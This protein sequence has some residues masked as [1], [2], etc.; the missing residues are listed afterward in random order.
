MEA[1]ALA[2]VMPAR[3]A[4]EASLVSMRAASVPLELSRGYWAA[5]GKPVAAQPA[6]KAVTKAPAPASEP[7]TPQAP[8]AKPALV[9]AKPA[10]VAAKPQPAAAA[11]KREAQAP[12]AAAPVAKPAPVKTA[13]AEAPMAKPVPAATAKPA[14]TTTTAKAADPVE[15]KPVSAA[16]SAKPTPVKPLP[17]DAARNGKPDD[18]TA[19][20]GLGP[21]LQELLN[22]MGIFHLDQIAGWSAGEAS[23]MDDNLQ[24]VKGRV[25]RDN[26]IAQAKALLDEK[27]S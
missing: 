1:A 12:V 13:E 20:K 26:W 17:I 7:A 4:L 14:P 11:V 24:G 9:A 3:F 22:R 27:V 6:A 16:A 2:M 18:L 10:P 8:A 19:I 5:F 21:K 15:A 25:T 23:W